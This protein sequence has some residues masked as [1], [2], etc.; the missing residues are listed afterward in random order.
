MRLLAALAA[1]LLSG[2]AWRAHAGPCAAY[3]PAATRAG[4]VPRELRELSGLAAS[5]RHP[6]VLWAHNDSGNAFV[7]FALRTDGRVLSAFPLRGAAPVD[8][9]DIAVGPCG[10]ASTRACVY[11]ADTGDNR[12]TRARVQVLR[13]EEPAAL[14]GSVLRATPLPFSYPDGAQD[15]EALL[16][17]PR[18]ARVFVVSKSFTSLGDAYRLDGLGTPAGGRAVPVA[19]LQ[20][21]VFDALTTGGDVH[22][23]GTR[24]LLRT[25]SGVWELRSPDA[26]TLEEVLATRPTAVPTAT[27]PQGEAVAYDRDG[28]GY[29][30]AGEGVGSPMVH[31][32]C[33]RAH[34]PRR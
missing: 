7:L 31:V 18:T 6:G 17:E 3:D 23:E 22:P 12:A 2:A 15:V 13:V 28:L 9:E 21:P 10:P 16:V 24:V 27:L 11:L 34:A 19:T 30:L 25:Y 26:R 33:H 20:A 29:T 1:I 4:S 8:I 32:A 5:R 14:D